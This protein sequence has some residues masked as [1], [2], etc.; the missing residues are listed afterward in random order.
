MGIGILWRLVSSVYCLS[1]PCLG[2]NLIR[3]GFQACLKGDTAPFV[4]KTG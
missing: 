3:S 4:F 1:L 2:G